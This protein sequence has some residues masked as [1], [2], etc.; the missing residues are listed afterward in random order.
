MK[1]GKWLLVLGW[2]AIL[3][4]FN[5][6]SHWSQNAD[7]NALYIFLQAIGYLTSPLELG[8]S[9]AVISGIIFSKR[10]PIADR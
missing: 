4:A 10:K 6:A 3:M 8:L 1:Y 7:N 5:V 2:F 9:V